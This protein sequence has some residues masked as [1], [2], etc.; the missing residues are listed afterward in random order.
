MNIANDTIPAANGRAY[1][2][3]PPPIS[4]GTTRHDTTRHDTTRHDTTRHDTTRHDTTRHGDTHL[5]EVADAEFFDG[6]GLEGVLG[7][8]LTGDFGG[9]DRID[10]ALLIEQAQLLQLALGIVLQLPPLPTPKSHT[11]TTHDTHDT[12]GLAIAHDARHARGQE[13]VLFEIGVLHVLLR[14]DGDVFADGHRE[15]AGEEGGE[16]RDQYLALRVR[17]IGR[18][19]HLKFCK[20]LLI[21]IRIST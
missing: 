20:Y 12:R 4:N 6:V 19:A 13:G 3:S 1:D 9:G 15:R 21:N 11:R 14:G 16:G 2:H 10:A 7:H 5:R 18:H 17:L 8:Q